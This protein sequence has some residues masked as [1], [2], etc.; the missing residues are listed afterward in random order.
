M[1][2]Y[3]LYFGRKVLTAVRMMAG[4]SRQQVI[5]HAV[6]QHNRVPLCMPEYRLFEFE[7]MLERAKVFCEPFRA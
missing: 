3:W 6:A 1:K 2:T 4:M 7:F 5:A